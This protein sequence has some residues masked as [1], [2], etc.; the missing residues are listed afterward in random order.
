MQAAQTVEGFKIHI[1]VANALPLVMGSRQRMFPL[2]GSPGSFLDVGME[3]LVF[4]VSATALTTL[5]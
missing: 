5:A 2:Q 4:Y 3:L 1:G